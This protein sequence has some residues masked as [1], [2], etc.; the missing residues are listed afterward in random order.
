[1]NRFYFPHNR[2]YFILELKI[3]FILF[4][5]V[6]LV[7]EIWFDSIWSTFLQILKNT[8]KSVGKSE[9][10]LTSFPTILEIHWY[11][12]EMEN[13]QPFQ[14]TNYNL[15]LSLENPISQCFLTKSNLKRLK[16][17]FLFKILRRVKSTTTIW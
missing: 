16:F 12:S 9:E 6:Y 3:G 1:M 4:I 5:R 11:N 14:K 15:A 2:F 8:L 17:S 10:N 7:T 13:L